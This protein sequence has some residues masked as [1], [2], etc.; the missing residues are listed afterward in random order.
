MLCKNR[1]L[2][3]DWIEANMPDLAT[4]LAAQPDLK[5]CLRLLNEASGL[6]LT[7][8]ENVEKTAPLILAALQAKSITERKS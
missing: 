8:A 5:A 3:A 2:L 1:L 6:S 7:S 4:Q